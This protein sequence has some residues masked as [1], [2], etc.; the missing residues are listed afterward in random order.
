MV[1]IC[2]LG[3]RRPFFSS[4]PPAHPVVKVPVEAGLPSV[5]QIVGPEACE[6]LHGDMPAQPDGKY[7]ARADDSFA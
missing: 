1:R 7:R 3:T 2:H 4:R 6:K 5:K